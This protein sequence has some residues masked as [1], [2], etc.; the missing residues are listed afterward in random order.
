M[1]RK[2]HAPAMA[3]GFT[4][5]EA[6]IVI[7]ISGIVAAIVALFIRSPVEGY[8]DTV[9]RSELTEAADTALR[10]VARDV[11]AALPNSLRA[12]TTS[13][14]FEFLPVVGGGRYRVAQ[15][16]A[17]PTGDI[18]D[19]TSNDNSFDVLAS[20]GLPPPG[21]VSP[22]TYPDSHFVVIYNLGIPGAD[23]YANFL[24]K[25][26]IATSST[27]ETIT[28]NAHA[29]AFPFESPG[30]RFQV[31]AP[32]SVAYSCAN[33]ALRRSEQKISAAPLDCPASGPILVGNVDCAQSAFEYAPAA[34]QRN[35][36]LTMRLVLTAPG[37]R[38]VAQ[39]ISLYQ[40][41]HVDNTP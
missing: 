27:A 16:A 34:A 21:A 5:I 17:P 20:V 25:S 33:G 22:A 26:P 35:G 30:M 41:V 39:T 9:V 1:I 6:V 31:I 15:S 13:S 3:R 32:K 7:V 11:R 29:Q 19:F 8:V 36:L 18:L 24:V 12:G 23:A 4:L 40:E 2:R 28:L 37:A 38:G 14:C 10:R